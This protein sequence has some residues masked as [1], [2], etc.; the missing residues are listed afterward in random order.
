MTDTAACIAAL[1]L[2][3]GEE[4]FLGLLRAGHFDSR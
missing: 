1:E 4:G 3:F 2:E